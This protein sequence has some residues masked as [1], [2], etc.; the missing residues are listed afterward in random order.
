MEGQ[1][2]H[3]VYGGLGLVLILSCLLP[4]TAEGLPDGPAPDAVRLKGVRKLT[5]VAQ[6]TGRESIN[7]TD[8][9]AVAG[10][11]LGFMVEMDGEMFMVFGGTFG[12]I[13]L[14]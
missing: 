7:R 9:F 14:V 5:R 12:P 3:R 8:R 2:R 1:V 13:R 10:T 6:L 4:A 11:D